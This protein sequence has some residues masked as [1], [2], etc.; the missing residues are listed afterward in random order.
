M[1]DCRTYRRD[2]FELIDG[3]LEGEARKRLEQH[4]REC[5]SCKD[6]FEEESSLQKESTTR[7]EL[8]EKLELRDSLLQEISTRITEIHTQITA[9][10]R[11]PQEKKKGGKA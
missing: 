4:L 9:V 5:G 7:V 10:E 3:S 11:G 8:A 6:F 1:R 2:I